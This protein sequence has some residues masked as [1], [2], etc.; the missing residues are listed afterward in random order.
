MWGNWMT[1]LQRSS[2]IKYVEMSTIVEDQ[3][4][5][6]KVLSIAEVN[7]P[8]KVPISNMTLSKEFVGIHDSAT[9]GKS[10]H[11]MGN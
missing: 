8:Y 11:G 7:R 6:P 3:E 2:I 10:Y 5:K 1:R 4:S 9:L